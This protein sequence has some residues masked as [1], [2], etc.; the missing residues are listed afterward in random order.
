M[1]KIMEYRN[2]FSAT[3]LCVKEIKYEENKQN[4]R[5]YS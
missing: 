3:S 4:G 2:V 5:H 1:D